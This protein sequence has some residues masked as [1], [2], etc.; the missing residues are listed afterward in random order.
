LQPGSSINEFHAIFLQFVCNRAENS[1]SVLFLEPEQQPHCAQI[2]A[3]IKKVPGGDLS[4]HDALTDPMVRQRCDHLGKLAD[5]DPDDLIDQL[6]ELR[7]GLVLERHGDKA[8]DPEAAGLAG[9]QER[10]RP[11]TGDE[12][13]CLKGQ[14][15]ATRSN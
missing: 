1:V 8:L 12:A 2:R 14:I 11:A 5:L 9:K 15:H 6:G 10:Q 4:K 7:I 13:A 3:D